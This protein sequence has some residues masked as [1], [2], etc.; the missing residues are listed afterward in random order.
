MRRLIPV[1]A[2][3]VLILA[4]QISLA[5]VASH[6]KLT[7]EY[8]IVTKVDKMLE[9]SFSQMRK[10]QLAEVQSFDFQTEDEESILAIHDEVREFLE[11]KMCWKN[12]KSKYIKL[13]M[14]TFSEREL[15][16][17]IKFY[18]SRAGKKMLELTPDVMIQSMQLTQLSAEKMVKDIRH[19]VK[20]FEDDISGNN[21]TPIVDQNV[22][23]QSLN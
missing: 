15:K 18:K 6:R 7:E 20:E 2:A 11:E 16:Q 5:D 19:I 1:W 21:N 17:Y 13:Y 14:S 3:L 12:L 8:L 22:E 10:M 23:A 9:H 4:C